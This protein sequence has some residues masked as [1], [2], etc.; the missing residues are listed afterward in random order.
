MGKEALAHKNKMQWFQQLHS[1]RILA[2]CVE[3]DWTYEQMMGM[4][5]RVR[6]FFFC[7]D[8]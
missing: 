2:A 3:H 8:S 4:L 1:Q 5:P 7:K 6:S